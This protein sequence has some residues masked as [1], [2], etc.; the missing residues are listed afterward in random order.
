[1]ELKWHQGTPDD[2]Q[3]RVLNALNRSDGK[4][5]EWLHDVHEMVYGFRPVNKIFSGGV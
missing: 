3:G 1:M 2:G 5:C 4:R